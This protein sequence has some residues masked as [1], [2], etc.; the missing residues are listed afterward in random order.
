MKAPGDSLLSSPV[1]RRRVAE[2]GK[3]IS[4]RYQD[5]PLTVIGL[6]NGSIFFLVDLVRRLPIETQVECWRVQ[7]YAGRAS[8]G[9][10]K[11]LEHCQAELKGRHAIIV[12]DILDTGLTLDA[13]QQHVRDLGAESVEICVLL[14]KKRRRTV[15]IRPRWV[16][17]DIPDRFV[18]GY[19]LDDDGK[20]R[21]LNSIRALD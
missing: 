9:V 1:L 4:R 11:G 17:F 6:M 21:G 3:D 19:G 5:K 2:L 16:G 12:D 8:S 7:S 13:V 10:L 18:V 14:R 20:Y 15:K